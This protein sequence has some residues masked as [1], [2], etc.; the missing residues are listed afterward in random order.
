MIYDGHA[1]S[2]PDLRGNGGWTDRDEYM[3]HLQLAVAVHF[4]PA[5]RA[6][7]RSP[8]DSS[9]LADL[10]RGWGFDTLKECQFRPAG[11]GRFEWTAD[12][13]VYYKQMLS[14][15][16]AEMTF[17]P[18]MLIA[19]M[20]FA[21]VQRAL[22]H[23]TAYL[24]VGNGYIAD[25]VKRFPER[26]Q[27]LAYVEEWLVQTDP[28]EAIARLMRGIDEF[29]LHGLQF[30]PHNLDLYG[31]MDAWD[32]EGFRPFWNAV[33][34]LN[35]PVFF[36]LVGRAGRLADT[37]N[38]GSPEAVQGYL[39]ELRTLG[40]WMERYPDV[41]VVVTHGLSWRLFATQD[42]IDLPESV[43]EAAPVGNPNFHV[44]V[45]FPNF[46]GRQWEYPTPQVRPA[47]EMLVK[48]LGADRLIWGTDLPFLLRHYTYRQ[49]LDYIRLYYDFLGPQKLPPIKHGDMLRARPRYEGS[50]DLPD[51]MALILGGNMARIM[52]VDEE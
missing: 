39:E 29:E 48:R 43:F 21:G 35:I 46:F 25:C 2:F 3:R 19:Q 10:S 36:T 45:Q 20:D 50:H 34:G 15:G 16:L 41:T 11:H 1:Y 4:Q 8:A 23:R 18:E 7:D 17:T 6:K 9:G 51:E 27:G 40:R 24:G 47:F 13:E 49:S 31:Q 42:G 30:H 22:L 38:G 32:S 28:D 14:P 26:L 33:A 5:F 12:G 37:L 44:Q 52:K